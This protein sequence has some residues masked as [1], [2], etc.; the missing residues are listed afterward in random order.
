[1][2]QRWPAVQRA[3]SAAP[4]RRQSGKASATK[5]SHS[6]LAPRA[7]RTQAHTHLPAHLRRH[8]HRHRPKQQH[9][10]QRPHHR[11]NLHRVAHPG[12]P[13]GGAPSRSWRAPPRPRTPRAGGAETA[14]RG[15]RA[16][17]AAEARAERG[18]RPEGRPVPLQPRP[19]RGSAP[20]PT[21]C[22]C[23]SPSGPPAAGSGRSPSARTHA[24][25][26]PHPRQEAEQAAEPSGRE[27]LS[28]P[29]S[30]PPRGASWV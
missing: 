3:S 12:A 26:E 13:Q 11:Q 9:H 16:P 21:L 1:M 2:G 5:A 25:N 28:L 8:A 6:C 24:G 22:D 27:R 30:R 20:L 19:S 18:A 29:C 17:P 4:K 7:S 14:T 23:A 10:H 15:G